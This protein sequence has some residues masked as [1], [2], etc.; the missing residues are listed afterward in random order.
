MVRKGRKLVLVLVCVIG[1]LALTAG[2]RKQVELTPHEEEIAQRIGFEKEVLKLVKRETGEEHLHRL[3]G[4]DAEGYQI[5]ANGICVSVP[6]DRTEQILARLRQ[7]LRPLRYMAFVVELNANIKMDKI[8]VL[9]GVDQY[10]ILRV[11]QTNGSGYDLETEDIIEKLREWEKRTPFD[12]IGADFDWVEVEFKKL[13][14]KLM[15]F[16]EDVEEFAP[17]SVDDGALGLDE[18]A[19]EMQKTRRLFLLWE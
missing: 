9:K 5:M 8:G 4:Y 14:K 16:A 2:A 11:M 13:P 12:I 6:H 10:E 18:L 3:T 7:K 15:A 1:S 19:E 17:D